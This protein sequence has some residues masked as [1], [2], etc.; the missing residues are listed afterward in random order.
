M[1][2][3]DPAVFIE[4]GGPSIAERM[5]RGSGTKVTFVRADNKRIPGWDQ[6]RARLKGN[7][8]D[9]PMIYVCANCT[10]IIRTL[11]ALQ[12]DERHPEDVN[13]E[14]EDHAPDELRYGCMSRPW[15]QDRTPPK[16]AIQTIH[17]VSLDQVWEMAGKTTKRDTRI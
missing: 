13:T 3:A 10:D 14:S 6:V 12:H 4:D 7:E 9:Q 8:D 1:C 16:P 2:Y 15:V 17:D 5:F 11:P